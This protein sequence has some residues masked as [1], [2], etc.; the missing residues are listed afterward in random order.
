VEAVKVAREAQAKEAG[1]AQQATKTRDA[2]IAE[3]RAYMTDFRTIAKIALAEVPQL[4][5]RIGIVDR[6]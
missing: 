3:A 6:G 1:E 2:A 5:E 4:S